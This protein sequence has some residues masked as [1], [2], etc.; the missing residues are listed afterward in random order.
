MVGCAVPAAGQPLVKSAVQ[1][2]AGNLAQINTSFGYRLTYDCSSTSGPC[3]NGEVIDLLP[4]EVQFLSA[5][6]TGDVAAVNVTPNFS[7]SGR[8]RVQ[9]VMVNPL[10]AGNSGDL[11]ISVKF[12]T[13]TAAA[14]TAVNTADAINLGTTPGTFTTPPVTVTAQGPT[15]PT[16]TALISSMNPSTVGQS[17]TFTATVTGSSPTGTVTFKDGSTVLGSPS[18]S[19]G[20]ATFTTSSLTVGP[21]SITAAYSGD[22]NNG[23]STATTLTQNVNDL[24][25]TTTGLIS[26][27]NPSAFGQSVTFTATVTGSSPTGT[28]TFK[29]GLTVLGSPTLSGGTATFTISSLTVGPHSISASYSGDANN[30]ASAS[31]PL[32]QGVGTAVTTT[33]LVSSQNPSTFGQAVTFTATVTGASPTGTV[34]FKDGTAVLG[35][36]GL[37][38]TAASFTT[39][40]LALGAHAIT[41]VYSGDANNSTSTSPAVNQAV[42]VPADSI[43]L[44]ALQTGVSRLVAQGS[45]AATSGAIDSAIAE[46]FDDTGQLVSSNG[47]G[48]RVNFAAEP[49]SRGALEQ[50]VGSA[51]AALEGTEHGQKLP[52]KSPEIVVPKDWLAWLDV[53]GTAWT[54]GMQTGDIWGG[55][56]NALA[57]LTRR[58]TPD[59]LVG[60]FGGYEQFDYTSRL[61]DGRLK[62]GGWTAGGYLGWRLLP[63]L[64]FDTGVARSGISYDGQAGTAAGTFPGQRWLVTAGL[65]GRY[66]GVPGFVIEPSAKVFVLWEHQDAYTDSL[67]VAHDKFEFATGRASTGMKVAYAWPWMSGMRLSPY[68]GIYADYYFN[69]DNVVPLGAPALLPIEVV[70]GLSA[71]VTS[72]LVMSATAGVTLS[73]DSELGGIG[74]D[75]KVWTVRGRA[76]V[77]F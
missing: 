27:L 18:L 35:T 48:L 56:V 9:F 22:L 72:G 64:R 66:K 40:S 32:S 2:S 29:D 21:H 43:R 59:L 5:V 7:G 16:T 44:Q 6:P 76:S 73:L 60:A 42:G 4:A 46:G 23:T 68:A 75:F 39:S 55:Q 37:V 8:T 12:P 47:S 36:V 62:G 28:V 26:S 15:T 49:P 61:L 20:I 57:G 45:G 41:A 63:G 30:A 1:V 33:A 11:I 54:T 67:G 25:S 65:T 74:N 10:T 51:F 38:G 58:L 50:R 14:T 13:G 77:P 24:V 34:A 70:H 52:F 19:G 69:R 17:V 31:T 71:R 3:L 53:R